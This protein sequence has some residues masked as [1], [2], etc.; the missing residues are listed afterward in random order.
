MSRAC[1]L[2]TLIDNGLVGVGL[3]ANTMSNN[4]V[5]QTMAFWYARQ[6]HGLK[7]RS[8]KPH[9]D[10]SNAARSVCRGTILSGELLLW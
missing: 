10:T 6:R 7:N 8:P 3:R 1:E 9:L 5:N 4:D 2:Y